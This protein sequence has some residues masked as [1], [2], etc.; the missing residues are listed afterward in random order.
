MAVA[1]HAPNP[2]H[3]GVHAPYALMLATCMCFLCIQ[4]ILYLR[5]WKNHATVHAFRVWHTFIV[6]GLG[7]LAHVCFGHNLLENSRNVPFLGATPLKF[8]RRTRC[9]GRRYQRPSFSPSTRGFTWFQV[10]VAYHAPNPCHGGVHA[11][12]VLMLAT[13]MCFLCIQPNPSLAFMEEPCNC[14]RIQ[15]LAHI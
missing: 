6:L 1:Y 8:A 5:L 11:P 7:F 13:C 14:A 3:G 2:C 12:Y 4:A 9:R 15:G 10:A